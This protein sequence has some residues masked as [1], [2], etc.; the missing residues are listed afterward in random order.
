MKNSHDGQSISIAGSELRYTDAGSGNPVLLLQPV[1]NR[2]LTDQLAANFRVIGVEVQDTSKVLQAPR[3]LSLLLEQLSLSKCCLIAQSH[4]AFTAVEHA[5]ESVDSVEALV[6]IAPKMPTALSDALGEPAL[7]EIRAPALVLFGTR[8]HVVA[9]ETGRTYARRIPK[10]FYTLIYDA[11]H[12]IGAD[13]PQAL[14]AI[15][16]DFLEQREKFLVPHESSAIN[17]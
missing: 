9:P 6:L 3:L 14:C 15:V 16:R 10:C 12:D 4:L 1:L 17:P 11:G 7:E 13:R 5:I 8:D 2:A